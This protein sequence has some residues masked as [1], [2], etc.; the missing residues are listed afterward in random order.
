MPPRSALRE[1]GDQ[2]RDL[3]T[4]QD[5]STAAPHPEE[6]RATI[7][8]RIGNGISVNATARATPAGLVSA[9]LLLSAILIPVLLIVKQRR[10]IP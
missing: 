3:P 10:I 7:D 1:A 2:Q 5:S 8:F 9:A 6:M 4:D